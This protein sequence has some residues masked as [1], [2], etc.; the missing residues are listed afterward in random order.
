MQSRA[1]TELLL[2]YLDGMIDPASI[3]QVEARLK[4][5]P[6]FADELLRLARNEA[7]IGEWVRSNSFVETATVP[8]VKLLR[9]RIVAWIGVAAVCAAILIALGVFVGRPG[10][11]LPPGTALARLETVVGDVEIVTPDGSSF[12]AEEGQPLF[13]GHE[14]RTGGAGSSTVLRWFDSSRLELKADTRVRLEKVTKSRPKA[15]VR[16]GLVAAEVAERPNGGALIVA[17]EAAEV[18]GLV[19][20]VSFATLPEMTYVEADEGSFR[21]TRMSDGQSIHLSRGYFAVASNKSPLIPQQSLSKLVDAHSVLSHGTGAVSGL[22]YRR[23][24]T[25]LISTN[26]DGAIRFWDLEHGNWSS[27]RVSRPLP[28]R[29]I[30]VAASH[31]LADMLAVAADDRQVRLIE[32]KTGAEQF[33]G[34]PFRGRINTMAFSPDGG[35]LAIAW[36]TAKE[37]HDVQILNLTTM[38]LQTLLTD[39]SA[40]VTTLTFANDGT[41]ATGSVDR[42][43][44]LWDVRQSQLLRTLTKFPG[45]VRSLAF[46]PDNSLLAVGCRNG[47]LKLWDMSAMAERGRCT[48]HLR[49][50]SALAFSLDGRAIASGS[51]DGTARL[52]DACDGHELALFKGH[53]QAVGC[54][55]FHPSGQMLAT[56]G[57]DKKIRIWDIPAVDP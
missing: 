33:V 4:S 32:W 57:A 21:L 38:T 36:H 26:H 16:E 27:P 30:R 22:F 37:S 25:G 24:G 54:V 53:Q 52:W 5:D 1:D 12:L 56:G 3:S 14:V 17:S 7:V 49:E 31:P 50:V 15:F 10:N 35:F 45:E 9:R 6:P 34:K 42:T 55:A 13:A 20:R 47:A 39:H 48:G 28:K 11:T 43:V 23:D 40:P 51:A 19:G 29:A 8:T 41:L 18:R 44:K 2:A 46:A